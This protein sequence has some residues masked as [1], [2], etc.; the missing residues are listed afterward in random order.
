MSC[1]AS[2]PSRLAEAPAAPSP[3]GAPGAAPI[4]CEVPDVSVVIPVYNE[5]ESVPELYR[6]IREALERIG[7]TFEAIF[8]DDGSTDD[9]GRVLE[10][11]AARDPRVVVIHFR[12]N[13]GQSAAMSAGFE[14]ARA[15]LIVA[16]DADLQ[17]DPRDIAAMLAKLEEG[18]D[19]VSG[20]RKD[21]KD[22]LSKRLPSRIANRLISFVSG[23]RL[24]DYGCALKVYRREVLE[25]VILYGEMHRFTPIYAS[26]RG[27]RVTEI[28][29][30]H[31]PRRH[32]K[33]HYGLER[34]LKVLLDLMVV[35]F[36]ASTMT[37]PMYVFGGFGLFSLALGLLTWALALI[38]KFMPEG[39]YF[40]DIELHKNL[41]RTPLPVIGSFLAMLGIVMLLQGLLAEMLV[42]TYFESQGKRAYSVRSVCDRRPP[43]P[44]APSAP[45]AASAE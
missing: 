36:F 45:P 41:M 23:V 18:Y 33:S 40:L 3:D 16:M 32:G 9:S 4:A 43:R 26:L 13:F 44:A 15:P 1:G 19:V 31:E 17:N 20:W 7:R 12:R 2:E 6:R 24:R 10:E 30:S 11:I 28:A 25:G 14:S 29:V 27:A 37:K 22:P 5:A 38:F 35:K 42:R 8:V 39:L 21:R 34:T